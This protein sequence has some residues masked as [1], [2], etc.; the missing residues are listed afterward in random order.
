MSSRKIHNPEIERIIE[1]QMRQWEI[2]QSEQAKQQ[3]ARLADDEGQKID[4]ITLSR[5]LGSGGEQIAQI[6]SDQLDWHIY[7]K[8][9]LDYMA[10]DMHVHKSVLESVDEKTIGW[11]EDW[12]G[13]VF[14]DKSVGQ[15]SY[16]HHLAKVLL[17]ISQHG[18]AIIIG[19]AAGL[20]LPRENGLSVRVMAPPELRCKR[21][22]SENEL[23]AAE[24]KSVMEKSDRAQQS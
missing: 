19:R 5:E 9:I 22:A 24:A 6:L 8:E 23:N 16:Y 13:P 7:D 17:V 21:Y 15:L 11:I 20:L 18:R 3:H 2:G 1:R 4:F 10:E 12:L 14:T